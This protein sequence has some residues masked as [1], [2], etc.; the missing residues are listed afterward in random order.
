MTGDYGIIPHQAYSS[1]GWWPPMCE[2]C[3]TWQCLLCLTWR[4]LKEMLLMFLVSTGFAHSL[5]MCDK[6]QFTDFGSF[7]LKTTKARLLNAIK[8][9][10][11]TISPRLLLTKWP[12]DISNTFLFR[13]NYFKTYRCV[14][15]E[16]APKKVRVNSVNP[17]VIVTELQKT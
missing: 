14:A 13:Q 8:G 12:G 16:L 17:G 15:L 6:Y 11:P 9:S 10:W 1:S 7:S 2:Q 4:K 3:Y 5:G